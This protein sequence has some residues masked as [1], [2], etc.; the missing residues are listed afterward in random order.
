[1]PESLNIKLSSRSK[2]LPKISSISISELAAWAIVYEDGVVTT[3]LAIDGTFKDA[4]SDTHSD[5]KSITLGPAG[6]WIILRADGTFAH[7]RLPSGLE[8]LFN[9]RTRYDPKIEAISLG[10]F[11]SWFI[12]FDDGECLWEGLPKSLEKF[13]IKMIRKGHQGI[14]VSLSIISPSNYFVAIGSDAEVAFNN[15]NFRKALTLEETEGVN[16]A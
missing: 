10:A 15:I 11:G 14:L 3:S 7:E 12:R 16:Y 4:L 6:A 1:M 9:M 13:L 5:I 8:S 2:A